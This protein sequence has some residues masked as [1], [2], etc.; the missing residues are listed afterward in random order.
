MGCSSALCYTG[1][2][3]GCC[4]EQR[5]LARASSSS[6]NCIFSKTN[7]RRG[8]SCHYQ[9][10]CLK[11]ELPTACYAAHIT[12]NHSHIITFIVSLCPRVEW[13][14]DHCLSWTLPHYTSNGPFIS[15]RRFM[16]KSEIIR[17]NQL[18]RRFS[19]INFV[20]LIF[21]NTKVY[22]IFSDWR[23][24][25]GGEGAFRWCHIH[26]SAFQFKGIRHP[27]ALKKEYN[28]YQN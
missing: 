25:G 13:T 4:M 27:V 17:N 11:A 24:W 21:G 26:Y 1:L 22:Y 7:R 14:W 6:Q 16:L 15:S 8:C 18:A 20:E 23:V 28:N 19:F 12:R 5:L 2:F 9:R 10:T 3:N